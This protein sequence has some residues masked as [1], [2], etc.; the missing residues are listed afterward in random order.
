MCSSLISTL[1][2]FQVLIMFSK[3]LVYFDVF[4][5]VD[6]CNEINGWSLSLLE[7]CKPENVDGEMIMVDG[8]KI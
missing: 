6:I 8:S 7:C 1:A 2:H 4:G 3:N 5:L